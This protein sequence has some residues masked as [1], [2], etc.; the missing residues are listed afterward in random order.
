MNIPFKYL[1]TLNGPAYYQIC[2]VRYNHEKNGSLT[3]TFHSYSTNKEPRE[4]LMN[5]RTLSS[6]TL[7]FLLSGELHITWGE[8]RDVVVKAGE[9][10]FLP[11]GAEISGYIVGNVEVVVANI[12]R[13]MTGKELD[14]LRKM[15]DHEQFQKY[16]FKPME[17]C[18]PMLHLAESVKD[19]L[20][21]GVNCAHLHE[22]KAC[23]LYVVLHW[24]YS[25][26]DN[27]QLF[28]P[29]VGA[30]SEFRSFILNNFKVTTSIDA[31][32]E[33]S[34]M[35]RSTFDRK[36]KDTFN[37]TPGKWIDELTR[38]TIISKAS[39]P[40]VSVKDIMYEVGVYN[41]SQ[42]TTLCKR[43]CGVPPSQLIR[44]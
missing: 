7:S 37:T 36:F 24:F 28:Y 29:M 39:E 20:T 27:A 19:F 38:Q 43:L 5:T 15:K 17:M 21:M 33:K 42:F 14:D 2:P 31:L 34:N 18:P 30:I 1:G 41:P 3:Y 25:L 44:P 4:Q 35:S 6:H 10:Y 22:A 16:E 23:E 13:G 8:W 32:I 11:R 12:R 9:M 26:A 40:N